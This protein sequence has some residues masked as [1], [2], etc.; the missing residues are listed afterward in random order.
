LARALDLASGKASWPAIAG[1]LASEGYSAAAIKHIGKDASAQGEIARRIHAAEL[2]R[3]EASAPPCQT[4]RIEDPRS[5]A[6][7]RNE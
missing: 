1:A 4:W 3:L 5:R 7:L 2:Q 6:K